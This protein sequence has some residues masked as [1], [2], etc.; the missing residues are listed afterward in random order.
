MKVTISADIKE[1]AITIDDIL[2]AT[3]TMA[4]DQYRI[5][6][7]EKGYSILEEFDD[8]LVIEPL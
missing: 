1:S 7:D 3:G 4:L 2:F 6:D 8:T 5:L